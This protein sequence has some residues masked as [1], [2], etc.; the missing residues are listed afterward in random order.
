MTSRCHICNT[1]TARQNAIHAQHG[2]ALWPVQYLASTPGSPMNLAELKV[3]GPAAAA[4]EHRRGNSLLDVGPVD[5]SNVN[6]FRDVGGCENQHLSN[7]RAR[8]EGEGLPQRPSNSLR[9]CERTLLHRLSLSI[10]VSSAFTTRT[11]SEGSVPD[12]AALRAAVNDSTSSACMHMRDGRQRRTSL[13][14]VLTD[15][16][17]NECITV[18]H[19]LLDMGKQLHHKLATLREPLG[20]QAVGVDLKQCRSRVPAH[21]H[22]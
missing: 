6:G 11:A 4:K 1:T 15:Q 17:T 7:S 19:K 18:I 2:T 13:G 21:V 12:T 14:G 9:H 10:C 16:H 5:K 3:S 20:E 8:S 22:T